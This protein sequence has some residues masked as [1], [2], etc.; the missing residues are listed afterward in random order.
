MTNNLV[1]LLFIYTIFITNAY[2][3][4]CYTAA[5]WVTELSSTIDDFDEN[6][7]K[8][9]KE[10]EKLNEITNQRRLIE[11]EISR[12]NTQIMLVRKSN[13]E[14]LKEIEFLRAK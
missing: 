11:M 10:I 9:K 4:V 7:G 2:A 5:N 6:Y 3:V 1:K 13:Y 14:K 12:L 8:L